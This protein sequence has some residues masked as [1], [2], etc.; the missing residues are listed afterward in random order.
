ME[1]VIGFV[2]G[3]VSA[4]VIVFYLTRR[5]LAELK[6]EIADKNEQIRKAQAECTD[7]KV[8]IARLIEQQ[9]AAEQRLKDFA[10]AEKKLSDAFK[11]LSAE[12]L[13]NNN[14]QFLQ[15]AKTD[16]EKFQS[17]AKADLEKRQTAIDQLV[18]P[19]KESLA[20]VDTK[21]VE[22]DKSQTATF[23]GLTEQIKSL[24]DS[25]ATLKKETNNLVTAL[26]R[27]QVRGRWGEMQ[28]RR[29]VEI[30]GMVAHCDFD[31][32]S[33]TITDGKRTRPDMIINL[34]GDRKIVVDAKTPL[35]SY[36]DSIE[37]ASEQDRAA[38]LKDHARHVRTHIMN[39]SSKGYWDQFQPAPELV[40]MFLPGE[41][42]FSAALEQDAGLIE[43]G[44][45]RRVILATPTTL[46]ALLRAVAYGWRQEQVTRNAQ[47]ISSLGKD[48]YDRIRTLA[49]HLADLGR[50]IDRAAEAYNK[51]IGSLESRV[52]VSARKFRELGAA[53][54]DEID[55]LETIDKTTRTIQA[56]EFDEAADQ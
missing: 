7:L 27:P 52:L 48:L 18:K 44:G 36:L 40:V 21:I 37:A 23:A 6:P 28:L 1:Y 33:S 14:A 39:L 5:S 50:N 15:L 35:D 55:T 16:L 17:A 2:I 46:M 29:V 34:P 49:A 38:K 30:A 45:D 19:L 11:A 20:K 51:T 56:P 10:D 13:Q 12:A 31:E 25:E 32:Q 43:L 22:I 4:G 8:E 53:P 54:G 3:A 47:A 9:K 26:R 41:M 24:L 42:F